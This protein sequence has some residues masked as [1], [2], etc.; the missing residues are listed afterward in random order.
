[1][2][3]RTIL[4]LALALAA[5]SLTSNAQTETAANSNARTFV[6]NTSGD[7]MYYCN[8][9]M[10]PTSFPDGSCAEYDVLVNGV[11]SGRISPHKGGWQA[12]GVDG[13][14][15]LS[16][17]KGD[18]TVAV[19]A[20]NFE[21]PNVERVCI[22]ATM[23]AA[24]IDTSEYEDYLRRA[25][26][27]EETPHAGEDSEASF[28]TTS[29]NGSLLIDQEMPLRHSFYRIL[30]LEEGQQLRVVTSC[31]LPCSVDV[32]YLGG[33]YSFGSVSAFSNDKMSFGEAKLLYIPATTD[34][35]QGLSWK[36]KRFRGEPSTDFCVDIPKSGYYM[37]KWRSENN[38]VLSTAIVTLFASDTVS[39]GMQTI[40]YYEDAALSYSG[41]SCAIPANIPDY[42]VMTKGESADGYDPMLFVE[43]N[44]GGRIVGFSD[45]CN[46]AAKKEFGLSFRDAFVEQ[47]YKIKTSKVHVSNYSSSRPETTC[48]VVCG[49]R[50]DMLPDLPVASKSARRNESDMMETE[51]LDALRAAN[52]W[53]QL[54]IYDT[55]GKKVMSTSDGDTHSVQDRLN[56]GLYIVKATLG[57]GRFNIYKINI[58]K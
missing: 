24:H 15:R 58:K 51:G 36:R 29:D 5:L 49:L 30:S 3:K 48:H 47:T 52:N 25:R 14:P 34:E 7:G 37:L 1:M 55:S 2:S 16:L 50:T 57:D 31:Q 38:D 11:H 19:V 28:H 12:I 35:M 22:G 13:M 54:T 44:A 8:F 32:F 18:N 27:S 41:V 40:G 4:T 21:V 20:G 9:W 26:M 53:K 39:G 42:V 17:K 56:T 6:V 45:D 10:Q 23:D 43:G 33:K 46:S